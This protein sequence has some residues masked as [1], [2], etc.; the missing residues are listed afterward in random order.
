MLTRPFTSSLLCCAQHPTSA[1]AA[2]TFLRRPSPSRAEGAPPPPLLPRPRHPRRP[3]TRLAASGSTTRSTP[4]PGPSRLSGSRLSPSSGSDRR[5]AVPTGP[6]RVALMLDACVARCFVCAQL[7]H[8][9]STGALGSH[10]ATPGRP[11][12]RGRSGSRP[13]AC[14]CWRKVRLGARPRALEAG[15]RAGTL[16]SLEP[17]RAHLKARGRDD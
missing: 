6:R 2:A 1:D 3:S 17:G 12:G 15:P 13:R 7:A 16:A 10:R 8:L 14:H 4:W 5:P 11:A 9:S